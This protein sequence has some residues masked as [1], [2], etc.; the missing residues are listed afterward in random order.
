[1]KTLAMTLALVAQVATAA[2]VGQ[3][4]S[5]VGART[6]GSGQN[7]VEAGLGWPG[8]SVAYLRGVSSSVDLGVRGSF[9]WGLE[10]IVTRVMPGLKLQG[11]LKAK[12]VDSGPLSVG[13]TFEPGPLFA[14]PSPGSSVLGFAVPVELKLGIATSN[15]M[16]LGITAGVPFW[17][18]FGTSGGAYLPVLAGVGLEYFVSS[19]VVVFF[20]TRM[21]PTLALSQGTAEFTFDA[22]LGAAFRF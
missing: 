9:T 2:E 16:T 22:E 11:L 5:V 1:M 21:G 4:F 20:R 10:G 7:A 18:K 14:A 15:A 17:V 8:V 3:P 13:L 19:G 12:L 6:T